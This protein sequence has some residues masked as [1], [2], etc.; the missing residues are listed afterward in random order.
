MAL[1][2]IQEEFGPFRNANAYKIT[3]A[4]EKMATLPIQLY[5]AFSEVEPEAQSN[6]FIWKL[7]LDYTNLLNCKDLSA[8]IKVSGYNWLNVIFYEIEK[9]CVMRKRQRERELGID[10]VRKMQSQIREREKCNE[11]VVQ[12]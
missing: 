7:L 5:Q 2:E 6:T 12:E 10:D 8:V 4:L 3:H 9:I 11:N 1:F